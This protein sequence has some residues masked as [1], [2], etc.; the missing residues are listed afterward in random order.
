V[1]HTLSEKVEGMFRATGITQGVH[2]DWGASSFSVNLDVD[3]ERANRA[4]VTNADVANSAAAGISGKSLTL[5]R[6]GRFQ[7]PVMA[8][9][10]MEERGR[11]QDIENLY[12]YSAQGD[13]KVPLAGVARLNYGIEPT[14]IR[15]WN[16]ARTIIPMASPAE[17]KLASEVTAAMK[18]KAAAFEATM[19]PGYRMDIG[20]LAEE[21][22]KS[23]PTC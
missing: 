3:E 9:L 12:V 18:D 16:Y 19:P 15:R 2:N 14:K 5:L 20:G 10:R 23:F 21:Q 11:L 17:G 13:Q 1:L 6:E 4:G 8:R 22:K 7:I